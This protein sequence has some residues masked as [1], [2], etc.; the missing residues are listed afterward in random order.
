VPIVPNTEIVVLLGILAV[1]ELVVLPTVV[2]GAAVP[3]KRKCAVVPELT[4]IGFAVKASVKVV[5]IS[6]VLFPA[7]L[8]ETIWVAETKSAVLL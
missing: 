7:S 8:I 1:P 2:T 4:V 3:T 5:V 6:M